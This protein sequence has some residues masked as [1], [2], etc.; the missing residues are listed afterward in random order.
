MTLLEV[1]SMSREEQWKNEFF[2]RE[3]N[4][5]PGIDGMRNKLNIYDSNKLK[6]IESQIVLFK[7]QILDK[8]M[9]IAYKDQFNI[10][11]LKSIHDFLY[12]DIYDF[13]GQ[14]RNVNLKIK[15][16]AINGKIIQYTDADKINEELNLVMKH[17]NNNSWKDPHID[18]ETKLM[19]LGQVMTE[20][21]GIHMFNKGNTRACVAF[22]LQFAESIGLKLDKDY[23]REN[24]SYL[25]DSM[26]FYFTGNQENLQSFL[27]NAYIEKEKPSIEK[28][29]K[30]FV[31][32]V[33]IVEADKLIDEWINKKI[34]NTQ[35]KNWLSVNKRDVMLSL[36]QSGATNIIELEYA[37]ENFTDTLQKQ[38][39]KEEEED[40]EM[41]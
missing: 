27:H 13:A 14:L 5:A 28:I 6:K 38:E 33:S 2:S 37:F 18:D 23:F 8:V 31:D 29:N 25:K 4:K 34:E 36:I 26:I 3:G 20:L 40:L 16:E 39:V 35:L 41:E 15:E 9:N 17:F 32:S 10:D 19:G 22:T 21:W 30:K 24:A 7:S 11:R 12:G 1:L